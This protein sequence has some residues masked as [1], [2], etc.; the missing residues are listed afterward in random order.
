MPIGDWS[1]DQ[2]RR[3]VQSL[4]DTKRKSPELPSI[5]V[6]KIG[7]FLQFDGLSWVP[8]TKIDYSKLILTGSIKYSDMSTVLA[9]RP[10]GDV[11]THD[12]KTSDTSVTST[13]EALSNTIVN[14]SSITYDG[15]TAVMIEFFSPGVQVGA[16]AQLVILL[17]DNTANTEV[18]R[19]ASYVNPVASTHNYG[20]IYGKFRLTPAS[21]ARVYSVRAFRVTANGTVAAGTGGTG[22]N[23]PAFIRITKA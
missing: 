2:L 13:A 9:D 1:P 21:G 17:W 20:S 11:L 18:G 5:M 10:I 6:S 15:S 19:I 8:A 14:S 12:E 22:A 23:V 3:F 7:D 16:S 4:I